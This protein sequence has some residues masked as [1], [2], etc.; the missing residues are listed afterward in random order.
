M[1]LTN[2]CKKSTTVFHS[3][4]SLEKILLNHMTLIFIVLNVPSIKC[5][6]YCHMIRKSYYVSQ[7]LWIGK[8]KFY[9]LI[10]F[11]LPIHFIIICLLFHTKYWGPCSVFLALLM[12]WII[13]SDFFALLLKSFSLFFIIVIGLNY[14]CLNFFG[15]FKQ[16][17]SFSWCISHCYMLLKLNIFCQLWW[18]LL[19]LSVLS[20]YP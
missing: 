17:L 8:N 7:C 10:Q 4:Q 13:I 6:C 20:R 9:G 11:W 5:F 14:C 19:I 12:G 2:I 15:I 1:K 16:N 3:V 18:S